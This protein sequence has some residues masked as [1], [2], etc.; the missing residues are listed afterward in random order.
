MLPRPANGEVGVLA[1]LAGLAVGVAIA[2]CSAVL[3]SGVPTAGG[4]MSAAD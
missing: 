4:V 3:G 2:G 1:G